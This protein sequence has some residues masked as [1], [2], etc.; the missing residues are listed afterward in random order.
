MDQGQNLPPAGEEC[1]VLGSCNGFVLLRRADLDGYVRGQLWM[2]KLGM[3][4][5]VVAAAIMQVI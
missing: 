3:A 5:A 1:V 4:L 2:T